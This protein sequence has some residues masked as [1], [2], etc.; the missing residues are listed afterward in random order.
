MLFTGT[1]GSNWS[2]GVDVPTN[3][4]SR[5]FYF[6]DF[7]GTEG[8]RMTL[9]SST[10]NVGIGTTAPGY[11]LDVQGV[12]INVSGGLCIAADCKTAWSQVGG[13]QWTT[14]GSNIYYSTGNIGVGTA[15]PVR[16]LH[17]FGGNI[18]HQFSA[19]AGFG[20]GFFIARDN[21]HFVENAYFDG[22]AWKAIQS[23]KSAIIPTYTAGGYALYLRA[24]DTV[25][26][27]E[28]ART[29]TAPFVVKTDGK[30]GV[31]TTSPGSL[32]EVAKNQATGT[33]V[34][35]TNTNASGF[36]GTYYN[37]GFSA[38]TGGF[39]QWN[40]ATGASNLFVATGGAAP[41]YLGTNS[42]IRMTVMPTTGRVGI[43]TTNPDEELHVEGDIKVTGNIAA[44]YQDVA[45]WV[46]STQK[47][48]AG[49]VVVLDS[50][51][52][53]HVLAS[54]SGYD[55][56]VAGVVS[57]QPGVI[58]GEGGEGK[59][60]VATTGRVKVKVDATS[61]P[62]R[63]GDL[64]VTSD[65]EGVAMKS[66]PISIGGRK[67]HAPGTIIGKALEPLER[68]KGEILVLLSLQ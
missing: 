60:M 3:N 18:E 1:S 22:T 57:A 15:A 61:A 14:S 6:Y 5:D 55:T 40:N 19:T 53:N 12:Q 47:L 67:M 50:E 20:Y 4:G 17:V 46:P 24:D 28:A 26:P 56:S 38:S 23:G 44:K 31:G 2:L 39:V 42:S 32:L 52:S 25:R 13:S 34:R 35:V 45:E 33:E 63:I 8:P 64:L 43:G 48:E 65:V 27:A 54:S 36:A 37:G 68:G 51:N 41:L 58:L 16:R 49:T 7:A 21:N 10:G 66:E 9:K 62:I 29:Y 30:V 11:R 59:L